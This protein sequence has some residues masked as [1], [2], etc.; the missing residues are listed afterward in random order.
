MREILFRGKLL[1]NN[2]WVAGNLI[3]LDVGQRDKEYHIVSDRYINI[4]LDLMTVVIPETVGQWTGLVDKDGVKIFEGDIVWN[5]H[6]LVGV[7]VWGYGEF[8]IEFVDGQVKAYWD[9]TQYINQEHT[10]VLGNIHDNPELL[11]VD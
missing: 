4:Y 5:G 7:V 8:E 10:R 2:E 1:A 6:G 11:E 9:M 3:S